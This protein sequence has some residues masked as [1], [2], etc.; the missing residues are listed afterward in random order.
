M[1]RSTWPLLVL[2]TA[3][4]AEPVLPDTPAPEPRDPAPYLPDLEVQ[5][6]EPALSSAEVAAAI[7]DRFAALVTAVP[8]GFPAAFDAMMALAEPGCP[9]VVDASAGSRT[10]LEVPYSS[11][12]T[13]GGVT[14]EGSISYRH[15]AGTLDDY[16]N[17]VDG[18]EFYTPDFRVEAPDG[19]FLQASGYF[20]FNHTHGDYF[21]AGGSYCSGELRADD[22]TAGDD[23][24][25]RGDV[26]GLVS[27]YLGDYN[28]YRLG[29]VNAT[30][31]TEDADIVGVALQDLLWEPGLC[32]VELLGTGSI[33]EA[34][35]VWHDVVF[36]LR[37][38]ENDQIVGCD[39]CGDHLAAGAPQSEPV[40]NGDLTGLIDFSGGLPW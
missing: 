4:G 28:G 33:R 10:Q 27:V 9:T 18:M 22:A 39:G 20:N 19:R 40:C 37:D 17:Q 16:G 5:P 23:P 26:S 31:A 29:V 12:T 25:L 6:A 7:E 21:V 1:P 2:L 32:D 34:N 14:F 15:E 35:G 30:V 36:A 38:E 13:S 11:C 24:W 8:T 3:C